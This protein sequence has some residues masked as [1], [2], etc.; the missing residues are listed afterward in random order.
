MP[1][2]L[3]SVIKRLIFVRLGP[4]VYDWVEK[5]FGF[6]YEIIFYRP[7]KIAYPKDGAPGGGID[8]T[9][10]R[11]RELKKVFIEN[12]ICFIFG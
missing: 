11:Y 8:Y 12:D 9:I 6:K 3:K 5:Y 4:R 1:G 2:K 10:D 7:K